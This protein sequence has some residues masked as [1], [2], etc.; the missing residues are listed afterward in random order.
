[1]LKSTFLHIPGINEKT[2]LKL[3][4]NKI[5]SWKS[6]IDNHEK[7]DLNYKTKELIYKYSLIS[8]EKYNNKDYC[9]FSENLPF[10][11]HWRAYNDFSVCFLDIETTGLSK[12]Y[13]QITTIGIY[14]GTTSKVLVNGIDMHKFPEEISKYGLIVTFNGKTFDIP[15][16]EHKFKMKLNHMHVDLRYLLKK[17]GYSGGLKRIEKEIGICRNDEIGSVDG[18]EAVRLWKRYKAGDNNALKKL[19]EYNKADIENLK[20]LMDFAFDKSK[21]ECFCNLCIDN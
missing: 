18:Y 17:F 12:N 10:N 21:K 11:N 5:N 19:V 6:F 2:E 4:E 13:N 15:F 9:F 20:I 7:L 14:D 16:I 3:W 1:M 8:E